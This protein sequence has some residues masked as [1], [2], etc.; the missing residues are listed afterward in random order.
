M[1][2]SDSNDVVNNTF[3]DNN[4]YGINVSD[5]GS[6]NNTVHHNTFINNNGGGIQAYDNGTDNE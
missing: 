6:D 4:K 5:T 1:G 2:Y 3:I